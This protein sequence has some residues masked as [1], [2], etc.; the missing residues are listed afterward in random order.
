MLRL[1]IFHN[2][3]K[4]I[5]PMVSEFGLSFLHLLITLVLP[6]LMVIKVRY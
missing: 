5:G 4:L 2:L 3:V 1:L 6:Y